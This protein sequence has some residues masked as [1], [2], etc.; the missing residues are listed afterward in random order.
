MHAPFEQAPSRGQLER[1]IARFLRVAKMRVLSAAAAQMVLIAIADWYVGNKASLGILYVLPMMTAATVTTPFQTV[2]L[3]FVCSTLR[4][5]FDIPTPHLERLLRF[6]FA[7]I[8]YASSGLIVT[9]LIRNR[10]L[11][12]DHLSRMRREEELRRSLEEQLKV[13][14]ESSPAAILTVDSAGYVLA[15]N[16]AANELF[17]LPEDKTLQHKHIAEFLPLVAE[18]LNFR[19]GSSDLRSAMQCQGRRQNGEIFLA[20]TWFSSYTT[21]QGPRLSAIVVDISEEM[22]DREEDGLRQ[23]MRGNRIAVAAVSHEVRNLC[24]AISLLCS[25]LSQKHSLAQDDDFQGLSMLVKGLE[26]IASAE[27]QSRVQEDLG[28]VKLHQVL[29]DLKIVIEAAWREIDGTVHWDLPPAIPEV[30]GEHHGL[31]HAFLNLAQNSHRAVQ[32]CSKRELSIGVT[33]HERVASIRFRDSGPGILEPERLFEPFRPGTDGA[34]LG[35][36]V[37]RAVV[38]SYGGDLRFEQ[39]AFGAC[40]CVEIPCL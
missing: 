38:R 4:A 35:L 39:E 12:L 27:L 15:C 21:P 1:A 26:W 29:D 5:V 36:Y 25:N 32:L 19:P 10:R 7:V 6:P 2:A 30:L 16:R 33:V 23:L 22:R 40:F 20:H 34:G 31:L 11:V 17:L 9:A 24:D 28:V 3:A 18:A 14:V 13:L 8:A 37:S